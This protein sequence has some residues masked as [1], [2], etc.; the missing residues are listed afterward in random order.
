MLFLVCGAG[1]VLE[2][3][4]LLELLGLFVGTVSFDFISDEDAAGEDQARH[5]WCDRCADW[6]G[7]GVVE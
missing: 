6:F 1:G 5:L 4:E 2:W 3:F 7:R